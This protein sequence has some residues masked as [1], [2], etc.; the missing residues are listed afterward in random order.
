MQTYRAHSLN[1]LWLLI[2]A[3]IALFIV[4][5]VEPNLRLLLGLPSG[6]A[7]LHQP[8]AI[9]TN[10][11]VHGSLWHILFNMVSLYF[12]GSFLIRLIGEKNFL[13]VFFLG[14]LAGNVFFILLAPSYAL[15]IGAS[16]AVFALG[17]ALVM[18][19][20]RLP[21]IIIPIPIP[22]PLWVAIAIFLL[23]SFLPNIAWQAHLGGV[24]LGLMAGYYFRRKG[25]YAR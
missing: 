24:L 7:F 15:G 14:G 4:T 16:G 25:I 23:I 20:P 2:F 3:N 18:I 1:A 21:V 22:V 17:G 10:L 8:W 12:L 9:I 13:I 5:L 6:E 11:F 19:A